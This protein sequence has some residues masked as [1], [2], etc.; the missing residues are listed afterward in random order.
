MQD[1]SGNTLA[2]KRSR[3]R[4][5]RYLGWAWL[6]IVSIL[7]VVTVDIDSKAQGTP[8]ELVVLIVTWLSW[9]GAFLQ[10]R[11]GRSPDGPVSWVV[12]GLSRGLALMVSLTFLAAI[13]HA[14]FPGLG[15]AVRAWW[16][17]LI[18]HFVGR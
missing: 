11:W 17:W 4:Q 13:V 3:D 2:E 16:A 14:V 12:E 8:F 1:N 7:H 5:I 18:G 15:P 10:S 9:S 6:V